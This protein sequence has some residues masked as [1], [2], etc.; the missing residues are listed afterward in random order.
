MSPE[1]M[2]NGVAPTGASEN[3]ENQ[4]ET[5]Y[6][7]VTG[8]VD[9]YRSLANEISAPKQ[10]YAEVE[11]LPGDDLPEVPAKGG[12]V[13]TTNTAKFLTNSLDRVMN[14]TL[15]AVA[16]EDGDTDFSA[17][18]DEKAEMQE[19]WEAVFPDPSKQMPP[20][21]AA[22]VAFVLIYGLKLKEAVAIRKAHQRIEEDAKI[23]KQQEIENERL[24]REVELMREKRNE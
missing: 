19:Y 15:S 4:E 20:W 24:R 9:D 5:Q 1:D 7:F 14:I 13:L 17:D 2:F 21:L 6:K 16:G 8:T 11:P 12:K 18:K 3:Q 22:A 10:E 23:I